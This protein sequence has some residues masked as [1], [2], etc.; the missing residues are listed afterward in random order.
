MIDPV[1]LEILRCPIHPAGPPLTQR[2]HF[3][4]CAVDGCGYRV[5]DDIPR[6]LPEDAV[7]PARVEAEL[8]GAEVPQ[9]A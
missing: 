6:M 3:L 7:D 5:I 1:L 2:G 4:I 8:A 9:D